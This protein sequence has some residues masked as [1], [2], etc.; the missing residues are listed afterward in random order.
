[1]IQRVMTSVVTCW[2]SSGGTLTEQAPGSAIS[3]EDLKA[4]ETLAKKYVAGINLQER[5][6][7][8]AALDALEKFA[9]CACDRFLLQARD[10]SMA[11]FLPWVLEGQTTKLSL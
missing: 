1:M 8:I 11:A 5:F 4:Y 9:S 10:G 2:K 6:A 3:S 7:G